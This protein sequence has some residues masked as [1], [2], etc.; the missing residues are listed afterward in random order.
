MRSLSFLR[1]IK[2]I[3]SRYD[4]LYVSEIVSRSCCTDRTAL[5]ISAEWKFHNLFSSVYVGAKDF[6]AEYFGDDR[7]LVRFSTKICEALG[8][9]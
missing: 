3:T 7:W 8:W 1:W 6:D 9:V 2:S 5:N 4:R